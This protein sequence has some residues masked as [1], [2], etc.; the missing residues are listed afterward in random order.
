MAALECP[1]CRLVNPPGTE[2]CD[3]GWHFRLSYATGQ[4]QPRERQ[5][6]LVWVGVALVV[7]AVGLFMARVR[8]GIRSPIWPVTLL[9]IGLGF[10]F[11]RPK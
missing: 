9:L 4:K 8:F 3:C 11:R 7:A 1:N 6:P 10:V 5:Q 2:V